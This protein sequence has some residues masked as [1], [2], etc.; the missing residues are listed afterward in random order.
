MKLLLASLALG[1][2]AAAG[3]SWTLGGA[4]GSGALIGAWSGLA[5]GSG[6][7]L[8]QRWLLAAGS[9]HALNAFVLFFLAKL[10]LVLGGALALRASG[11]ADWVAFVVAFPTAVVWSTCTGWVGALATVRHRASGA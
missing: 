5:L 1:V 10:M 11:F 8:W 6:G 9:K 3:V 4:T 2:V 7:I